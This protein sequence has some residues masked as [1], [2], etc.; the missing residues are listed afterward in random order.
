MRA[1]AAILLASGCAGAGAPPSATPR[2]AVRQPMP[3]PARVVTTATHY[4]HAGPLWNRAVA[5]L[6]I[7]A[8]R[9][10]PGQPGQGYLLG[11]IRDAGAWRD[12]VAAAELRD[13]PDIDFAGQ[14]VVFAV[15]DART[16]SLSPATWKL[17]GAGQAVFTFGESGSEPYD[18]DAAPG[19][20]AVVDRAGVRSIAF[21]TLDGQ[22]LGTVA[23]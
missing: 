5:G 21:R 16:T 4:R 1:L 23:L 13:P 2:A 18:P 17:D 7:G 14:M 22:D 9:G 3:V 20:L 8:R 10:A 19:T 15:L 11:T 6:T 12:F